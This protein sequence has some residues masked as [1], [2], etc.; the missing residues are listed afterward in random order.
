MFYRCL[1]VLMFCVF[2]TAASAEVQKINNTSYG[3]VIEEAGPV[4]MANGVTV[5]AG[6]LFHSSVVNEDGSTFS[7]WCRGSQA[8]DDK[9]APVAGGGFCTL[10]AENGDLL[11]VWFGGGKWGVIGGTGEYAGATGSG[12]S[13]PVSQNPDG[14]AFVNRSMGEIVTK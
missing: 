13:E 12:S 9:G 10:V 7:Q 3:V 6:G 11:W 2:S 1:A 14:R 4:E 5:M 8:V